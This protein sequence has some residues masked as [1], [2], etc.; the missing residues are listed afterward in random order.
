MVAPRTRIMYIECKGAHTQE[1]WWGTTTSPASLTGSGRSG[2]VT[3]TKSGKGLYYQGKLFQR[4]KGFK[5]NYL[6]EGEWFWIRSEEVW[7]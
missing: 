2:R 1:H 3:F 7:R 4:A 6:S 5:A